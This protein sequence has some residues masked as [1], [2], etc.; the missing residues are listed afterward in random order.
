[1][2]VRLMLWMLLVSL[3]TF[4]VTAVTENIWLPKWEWGDDMATVLGLAL[5]VFLGFR[6]RSAYDRWWE[7]RTL[8][9]RLINETRNLSIK[10]AAFARVPSEER[11]AFAELLV[12]FPQA[13]RCH[14]RGQNESLSNVEALF[15]EIT[16]AQHRPGYIALQIFKYLDRWNRGNELATSI[17]ILERQANGLMEVCGA[18]ER[19]RNTPMVPSYRYMAWSSVVLYCLVSPWGMG[20]NLGWAGIP[21]VLLATSF[22]LAMELVAEAIEEPFGTERDDLP[23]ERY[24]G[25]IESFVRETL[26]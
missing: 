4:S 23:L 22:L 2:Y 5:G 9:G 18:C 19:I 11:R 15:P 24:C 26:S 20:M 16:S 21:I 14:L 1:M 25:T 17:R 8:W 12:A 7:A 10:T 13:L 3:Y 6:S